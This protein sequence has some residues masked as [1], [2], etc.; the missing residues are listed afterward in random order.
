MI[1]TCP[2]CQTRFNVPI[3]ALGEKGRKVRCAN[4]GNSWHQLPVEEEA[5]PPPPAPAPADTDDSEFSAP[6]DGDPDQGDEEGSAAAEDAKPGGESSRR[7]RAAARADR[8]AESGG[9]KGGF[10]GWLVL[11]LILAAIGA[12][13]FFYQAKIVEIWPPAGQLYALLKLGPVAEKFGLAIQNVKWEHTRNKGKPV[14]VVRGEVTNTSLK[15]Q[16]VPRLRVAIHD[17]NDRRLFRWTVTTAK[18]S[19]DPGEATAF[20][21]RLADPPDGARSLTVTFLVQP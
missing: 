15:P 18:N 20:S 21:T 11:I 7:N 16:S 14:L 12:G 4:C 8:G 13:G 9:G 3:T 6:D 17:E 19:L 5:P 1:L 2:A 10:V